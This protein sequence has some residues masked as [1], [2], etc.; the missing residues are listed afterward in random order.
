MFNNADIKFPTI[1]DENNNEI[2]VTKGRYN[3]LLQSHD[4]RTRKDAYNAL[5]GTY[6]NKLIN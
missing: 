5:Y 2:E 3:K 1:I 6:K 4:Q